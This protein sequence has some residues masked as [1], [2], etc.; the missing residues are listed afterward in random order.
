MAGVW[1]K[2]SILGGAQRSREASARQTDSA[3]AF[4][5][6]EN[7]KIKSFSSDIEP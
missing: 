6:I 7:T 2:N 3:I 4:G 5:G 1:G